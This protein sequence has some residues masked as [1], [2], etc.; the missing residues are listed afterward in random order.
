VNLSRAFGAQLRLTLLLALPFVAVLGAA[1][2]L[3]PWLGDKIARDVAEVVRV[4]RPVSAPSAPSAASAP[5]PPVSPDDV[6]GPSASPS[7]PSTGDASPSAPAAGSSA[8]ASKHP[9]PATHAT[10]SAEAEGDAGP[11]KAIHI[12]AA[13]V[14]RAIDDAGK[15]MLARTVRGPDGQPAGV[16]LTGVSG[17]GVGLRDGDRVVAIDGRATLDDDTATDVA[18]GAIA[19]GRSSLRVSL[20]R[21][22][23]PFEAT[24]DLPLAP[25][26]PS[27]APSGKSR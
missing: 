10:A 2:W 3:V 12:P 25:P 4:A 17:A 14:Q 20:M 7:S 5:P 27:A 11:P 13:A 1:R 19:R 24:V 6:P 26:L 9:A 23:Q 16:R 21:G 8:R 15:N 18:L 22:D